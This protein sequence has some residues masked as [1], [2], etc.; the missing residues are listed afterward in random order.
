MQIRQILKKPMI[1]TMYIK[2][3]LSKVPEADTVEPSQS[4]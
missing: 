1:L 2:M 3:A 4:R